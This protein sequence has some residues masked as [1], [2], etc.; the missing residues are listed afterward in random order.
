[1][2]INTGSGGLDVSAAGASTISVTSGALSL[3]ASSGAINIGDAGDAQNINIGT[4]AA[5]RVITIGN[6][7]GSTGLDL[8]AGTGDIALSTA[9][10]GTIT[11]TGAAAD[12][13]LTTT[14]SGDVTLSP[15]N[16]VNLTP[17]AGFNT[18][19]DTDALFAAAGGIEIN[20]VAGAVKGNIVY[21]NS[22]GDAVL[23]QNDVLGDALVD[24]VA[25][26]ANA[27]ATAVKRVG[28]VYGTKVFVK[29]AGT[30]PSVGDIAY[31]SD[32]A[33]E[34]TATLPTS[35]RIFQ[36]GRVIGGVSS[37]LYPV[38]FHP[39]YIADN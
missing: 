17:G 2:N 25:L 31:L 18:R 4:G 19:I 38:L 15:A 16:D 32:T 6:L 1:V 7:T 35:G 12:V 22:S 39:Q 9:T 30:A 37:S 28:T 10:G 23:A 21:I 13:T 29:F 34:A 36:I 8:K 24:G 3:N 20:L 26:E 27:G 5:A 14:T 33:G 11:A